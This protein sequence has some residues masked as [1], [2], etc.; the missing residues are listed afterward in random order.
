MLKGKY[1][2]RAFV[3]V[4]VCVCNEIAEN[5]K[6]KAGNHLLIALSSRRGG[7]ERGRGLRVRG[8]EI[9]IHAS[10]AV[11]GHWRLLSFVLPTFGSLPQSA[12]QSRQQMLLSALIISFVYVFVLVYVY[13]SVFVFSLAVFLCLCVRLWCARCFSTI[14][15]FSL[16]F[17]Y[18]FRSFRCF[19]YPSRVEQEQ[20]SELWLP[21]L[22]PPFAVSTFTE[23]K[24]AKS[25]F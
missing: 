10:C 2:T 7:R 22:P 4:C 19:A 9:G 20:L 13:A 23:S 21:P 16:F 18:F 3:C 14:W 25:N 1:G 17:R 15:S 8:T 6:Q 24:M 11:R 12:S 5:C